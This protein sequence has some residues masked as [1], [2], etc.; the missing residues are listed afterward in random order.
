MKYVIGFIVIV[1]GILM[2][3]KTEWLIENFGTN[4]WAESHLG[5]EG[6]TRLMY[7]V[8]GLLSVVLSLMGMTG[9]LGE[10]IL[11]IFGPLF[12]IKK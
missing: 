2:V 7:K 3:I 11:G 6:G 8:L 1:I 4:D 9:M 12:G 5:S 10:V